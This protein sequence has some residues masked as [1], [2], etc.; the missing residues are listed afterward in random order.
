MSELIKVVYKTCYMMLVLLL[1]LLENRKCNN[2]VII[3]I[4]TKSETGSVDFYLSLTINFLNQV[5]YAAKV[6]RTT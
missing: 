5:S 6:F 4:E 1:M 3:F 2:P